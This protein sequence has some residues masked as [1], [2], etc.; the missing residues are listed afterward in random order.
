MQQTSRKQQK[1]IRE[2]DIDIYDYIVYNKYEC[3]VSKII[4]IRN[5]KHICLKNYQV[6]DGTL[7]KLIC[8]SELISKDEKE[9]GTVI[10]YVKDNEN[11]K[12]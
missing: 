1:E 3:V 7:Y 5:N 12:M 8:N 11:D 9:Y 2:D 6:A 10:L 4:A